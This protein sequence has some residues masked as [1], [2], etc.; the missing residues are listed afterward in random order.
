MI[1]EFI[2]SFIAM[3][4]ILTPFTSVLAF[5]SLTKGCSGREK[6]KNALIA[7]GVAFSLLVVFVF[8]GPFLLEAMGACSIPFQHPCNS[9]HWK[10]QHK[11][12][13]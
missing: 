13:P 11:S 4:M 8:A 9:S 5:L 12:F 7:V 1:N 2:L 10:I 3:F 6:T